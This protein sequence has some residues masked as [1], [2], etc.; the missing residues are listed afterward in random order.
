MKKYLVTGGAGFIG[1]NYIN[2]LLDKEKDTLVINL[3]KLTYA[4]NLK[5][6]ATVERL[7][8]YQFVHGDIADEQ[9]LEQLFKKYDFDYIVNF[10]AESHVD[11]SIA[12]PD[13]FIKT[14]IVGTHKLLEI[15]RKRWLSNLNNKKFIQIST[16]E[17]Y[18]ELEAEGYFTE[19]TS[20]APR[21]PYSATKASADLLVMAYYNTYGLPIN[22]TRCS[23]NY[24]AYQY[25]EKLIPLVISKC[26]N[27]L[28]IPVYGDGLNI[29]DWLY[30]TEHCKAIDLVVAKGKIGEVYNI[31]GNNEVTNIDLVK[32][33]IKIVQNKL[34]D[35]QINESLINFVKDRQGHDKRYAIDASKIKRE[36]GWENKT[37]FKVGLDMTIEWYLKNEQWLKSV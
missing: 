12:E 29:R 22:I 4:G 26:L 24:G 16:D 37:D 8:N 9:L 34:G 27:H 35:Q 7:N 28:P 3:D 25:P 5:N 30:V 21:S 31:G 32:N 13:V 18:G 14:N 19:E 6:L 10:A 36:L 17:V 33:I 23:N 2:Y 11:R 20:I 15:A 1:S